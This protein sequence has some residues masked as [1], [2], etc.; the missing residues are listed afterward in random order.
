MMVLMTVALT[1]VHMKLQFS[2]PS[3]PKMMTKERPCARTG[4]SGL[5]SFESRKV[6]GKHRQLVGHSRNSLKGRQ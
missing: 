5:P 3:F 2:E 6:L 1:T 4:V